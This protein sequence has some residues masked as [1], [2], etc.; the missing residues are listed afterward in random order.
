MRFTFSEKIGKMVADGN[1]N[2]AIPVPDEKV[3]SLL[4]RFK[5]Q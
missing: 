1:G 4:R 5:A 3:I 2:Y